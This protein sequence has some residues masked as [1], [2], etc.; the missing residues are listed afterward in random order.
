MKKMTKLDKIKFLRSML[1]DRAISD[2][3][4][5][6]EDPMSADEILAAYKKFFISLQHAADNND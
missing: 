3:S 1:S 2:L 6:Y 4:K 5:R